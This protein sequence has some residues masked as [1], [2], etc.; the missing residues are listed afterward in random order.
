ML[1][2]L[3]VGQR[4]VLGF[5]LMMAGGLALA[6]LTAIQFQRFKAAA[7][8][9]RLQSLPAVVKLAQWD[10]QLQEIRRSQLEILFE[11][12]KEKRREKAQRSQSLLTA[13]VAKVQDGADRADEAKQRQA[14][15]KDLQTYADLSQA[16]PALAGDLAQAEALREL[17]THRAAVVGAAV[18]ER[19]SEAVQLELSNA[20]ASAQRGE[21]IQGSVRFTLVALSLSLLLLGSLLSWRITHST[22]GPLAAASAAAQRIASGDLQAT[23]LSQQAGEIGELQTSLS[24]MRRGLSQ[25]VTDIRSASQSVRY[26]A[27]EMAQGYGDLS[28]RTENSSLGLQA[29]LGSVHQLSDDSDRSHHSSDQV[30]GLAQEAASSV[31]QGSQVVQEVVHTMSAIE[32]ASLRIADITNVIDGIAFQTNILA[33]NAAVEA[34]RAGEQGRGFAVVAHEVRTLAQRAAAAAHEIKSLILN[35]RQKVETGS[36]LVAQAGKTMAE[37]RRQVLGVSQLL[38]DMRQGTAAQHSHVRE[39]RD[40]V[41]QL[42]SSTQQNAALVEQGSAAA[43]SLRQQAQQLTQLVAVFRL[44]DDGLNHPELHRTA[45][46]GH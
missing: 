13:L 30:N 28:L 9:V 33:L 6:L 20:S 42:D 44:G 41:E 16:L 36:R 10:H 23:K 4:L 7:D 32:E 12:D 25:M 35:S 24:Q 19:L 3:K 37:I 17:V 39:I 5:G 38:T 29:I 22:V 18:Q 14:L 1:G 46:P 21:Q 15:K 2:S 34:A 45:L 43:D 40:S 11:F 27:E 8:D 31:E 26:A